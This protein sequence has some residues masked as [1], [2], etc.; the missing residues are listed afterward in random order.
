MSDSIWPPRGS[1]TALQSAIEKSS[2]R[3]VAA[4]FLPT[5]A[6]TE[7]NLPL[8]GQLPTPLAPWNLYTPYY[9]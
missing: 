4:F 1:Q 2:A 7:G 6:M 5:E 9:R 8:S 3:L